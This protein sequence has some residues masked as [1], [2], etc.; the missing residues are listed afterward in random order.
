[1][2]RCRIHIATLSYTPGTSPARQTY[3]QHVVHNLLELFCRDVQDKPCAQVFE[4]VCTRLL[5]SCHRSTYTSTKQQR[6]SDTKHRLVRTEGKA[7]R[8]AIISASCRKICTCKKQSTCEA[9]LPRLPS[10][11]VQQHGHTI[12]YLVQSEPLRRRLTSIADL[13]SDGRSCSCLQQ[14]HL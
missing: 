13:V 1:M 12:A 9:S 6:R 2:H 3:E 5:V 4:Q 7:A 10:W 11:E 14:S 8:H